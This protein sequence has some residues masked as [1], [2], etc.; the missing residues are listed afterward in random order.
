[1]QRFGPAIVLVAVV[2]LTA[3]FVGVIR[4]K[5]FAAFPTGALV[6]LAVILTLPAVAV[7][8]FAVRRIR[9]RRR[10]RRLRYGGLAAVVALVWI[11]FAGFSTDVLEVDLIERVHI[12]E[13]GLLAYLLYR[14]YLRASPPVL[15][16]S[17]VLLPLMWVMFAGAL[18]EGTQ[19]LSATRMGYIADIWLNLFA[20]V[21]GLLFSFCLEP[22]ERFSWHPGDL[23]RLGNVGALAV[24]ALGLFFYKAHL[25]YRID[26]DEIGSFHSWLSHEELLRASEDRA[27]RWARDPPR[28]L[29]PW[30]REDLFLSEA[31]WHFRHRERSY[32]RGFFYLA[33]QANRILEK[34]YRPYLEL[35][36]F[37]R[38]GSRRYPP[39][40]VREIEARAETPD[41][42]FVSPVLRRRI[43]TW[44]SKPLFLGSLL[45]TVLLLWVLP[46]LARRRNGSSSSVRYRDDTQGF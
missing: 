17:L 22:P 19:L 7:L 32:E 13:Y 35:E 4:L 20:G 1:M 27:R 25:G 24:L 38:P 44:P 37:L 21:C 28:E 6:V 36:G 45:A 16:L 41:E 26:D 5:A 31:G 15:D 40:R 3:P 43:H 46:R 12:L 8:V 30:Q 33:L 9:H 18:D 34:Y 10:L 39:E 42:P 11:Q 2:V 29:L 23:R 14:A